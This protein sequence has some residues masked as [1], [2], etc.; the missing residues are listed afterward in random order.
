MAEQIIKDSYFRILGYIETKP[1]GDKIGKDS[2]RRIVGYY[3]AKTN[4]TKATRT[5]HAKMM[6]NM[7]RISFLVNLILKR[8]TSAQNSRSTRII[9]STISISAQNT[10]K[11]VPSATNT[12]MN[13]LLSA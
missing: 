5:Q 12:P 4:V 3:E 11:T 10:V 13:K 7:T 9:M 6:Q 2:Y 8:L 1:N